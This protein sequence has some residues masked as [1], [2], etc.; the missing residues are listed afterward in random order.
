MNAKYYFQQAERHLKQNKDREAKLLLEKAISMATID[1]NLPILIPANYAYA[2]LLLKYG[3]EKEAQGI[4]QFIIDK[5]AQN[6]KDW[7]GVFDKELQG[8]KNYFASFYSE[9]EKD[10]VVQH[11][12]NDWGLT[13]VRSFEELKEVMSKIAA[14]LSEYISGDDI[15]KVLG[16]QEDLSPIAVVDKDKRILTIGKKTIIFNANIETIISFK[17]LNVFC[18]AL[19][20]I[21]Q[22]GSIELQKQPINNLYCVDENCKILWSLQ[23]S[24]LNRREFCL[25]I[26]KVDEKT[27]RVWTTSNT[28]YDIDVMTMRI[29]KKKFIK[30]TLK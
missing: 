19:C 21:E 24:I 23:G 29:I 4:F 6:Q 15:A 7:Q 12:Q 22:D 1:N 30:N 18:V 13:Q 9:E 11:A 26:V 8:A 27:L 17:N 20:N 16:Y 5:V 10:K 3:K 28:V 25:D 14:T 2:N